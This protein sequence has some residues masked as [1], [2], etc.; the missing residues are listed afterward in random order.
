MSDKNKKGR[1]GV[2]YST[3]SDF[4]YE[5]EQES[6]QETLP[7]QQQNLKVMLDKK[8]RGG[9]QVTLVAGFVGTDDALKDLGKTLKSKCGVGGTVK[10]GE[11]LIQ[12]DFRDKVL[13]V[14]LSAGYKAKKAGG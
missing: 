5:Y 1:Q 12:G 8:A 9:K 7:P 13:Q 6:E 4:S 14:L 3:N 11:I 10:D 2:V